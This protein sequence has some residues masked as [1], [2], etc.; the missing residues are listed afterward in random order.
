MRYAER[1]ERGEV[2]THLVR[3]LQSRRLLRHEEARALVPL[4]HADAAAGARKIGE[5][6]RQEE[7]LHVE[8]NVEAALLEK[9]ARLSQK[10]QGAND[11]PLRHSAVERPP[12]PDDRL[13]DL[14][15][16]SHKL[17]SGRTGEPGD[18]RLR[19]SAAKRPRHGRRMKHVADGAQAYD[20]DART[21][22]IHTVL[23]SACIYVGASFC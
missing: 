2:A 16:G 14:G 21:R 1:R 9:R 17:R 12:V 4:A 20:E 22:K 23:L 13:V 7:I 6:A 19:Q 3:L 15:A 8:H 18:V 5:D 10:A 11:A